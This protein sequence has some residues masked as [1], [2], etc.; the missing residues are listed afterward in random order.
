MIGNDVVDIELAM[1]ESNWR[2]PGYLDKVFTAKEQQLILQAANPDTTVWNLWSR[3][4]AAYKIYNRQ[5]GIRALNP[6]QLQCTWL[7]EADG[8]VNIGRYVYWTRTTVSADLVRSIAV[9]EPAYFAKVTVINPNSVIKSND[10]PREVGT[11]APVS[12]SHHGR[13]LEIVKLT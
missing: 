13:F 10:L 6:L 11:G 3:K 8:R 5:T 4:E 7:T 1:R 2:R 9:F 12:V